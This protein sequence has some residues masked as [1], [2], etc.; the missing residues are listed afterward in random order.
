[1]SSAIL[2]PSI[3]AL[4]FKGVL[5]LMAR[6]ELF[7]KHTILAIFLIA[8]CALN[9]MEFLVLYHMDGQHALTLMRMYYVAAVFTAAAFLCLPLYLSKTH[10]FIHLSIYSIGGVLGFFTLFSNEA[11]TGV[12]LTSYSITRVAGDSYWVLQSFI[13][14]ASL[15]GLLLLTYIAINSKQLI[16]RQRSTIIL[17]CTAPFVI[18]ALLI[19]T[20]MAFNYNLN[21]TMILSALT[22]FMVGLLIYT[23]SK[24][25]LFMFLSYIPYTREHGI[26]AEA[27][28]LINQ[29]I[30]DLF[31]ERKK[32]PLKEMRSEFETALIKLA[33]EST[34]GN[35]THAAKVLG[36]GKATLHRKIEGLGL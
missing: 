31:D 8:L 32:L 28:K 18:T 26:R 10:P 12:Q 33:I 3:I 25:K 4:L 30:L 6:G 22:T 7:K 23:E 35:K 14:L 9:L 5:F 20:L 19:I 29:A 13:I 36:I 27:G 15:I 21:A 11:I 34:G 2:I 17:F 16:T 24:Y 1:M